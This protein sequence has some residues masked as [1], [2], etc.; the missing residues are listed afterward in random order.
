MIFLS[1]I[2]SDIVRNHMEN[3]Y[4]LYAKELIYTSY[5]IVHDHHEAEDI[6]QTA[7]IKVS[8]YIDENT[9]LKCNKMRGL[10]VII[11]KRLSYNVYNTRKSRVDINIDDIGEYLSD[12]KIE[13]PEINILRID[14]RKKVAKLMCSINESYMDIL[15]L[16]YTYDYSDSVIASMLN[17]TEGNVRTKLSRARRACL[18]IIG[19]ERLE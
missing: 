17:I 16:K 19:G 4:I 8:D 18:K 15:T 10:L 14:D 2:E 6:V 3:I 5:N 12:D 9:D 1:V 11:V 7:F 13:S